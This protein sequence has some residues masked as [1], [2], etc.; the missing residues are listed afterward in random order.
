M[1]LIEGSFSSSSKRAQAES[2]VQHFLDQSV[3]LVAIEQR[4]FGV[5]QVL[6]DQPDLAA[7]HV[8]GQV[9][10]FRQVEFLDQLA[11]DPSL[12]IFELDRLGVFGAPQRSHFDCHIASSTF[13]CV[14]I[15]TYV[16]H[17]SHGP[18]G[19]AF[20]SLPPGERA[21]DRRAVGARATQGY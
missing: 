15:E 21:R 6:H 18:L 4:P 14:S 10:D 16:A 12:Q 7:Q 20:A 17:L 13:R 8:A 11:V 2:L 5:A 3:A 9:A 1:S 19:P